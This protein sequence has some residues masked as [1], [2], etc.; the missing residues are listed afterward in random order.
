MDV[1]TIIAVM[2]AAGFV[3]AFLIKYGVF[4]VLVIAYTLLGVFTLVAVLIPLT[5]AI[6]IVLSIFRNDVPM[7]WMGLGGTAA[8]FLL[9]PLAW[10]AWEELEGFMGR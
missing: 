10:V 7:F 9:V 3:L 1:L 4:I 8:G 6:L 5:G 2:I